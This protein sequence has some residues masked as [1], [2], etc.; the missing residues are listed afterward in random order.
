MI[1]DK[2][3]NGPLPL[4]ILYSSLQAGVC[5]SLSSHHTKIKTNTVRNEPCLNAIYDKA[6]LHST[7]QV[8]IA[9]KLWIT[10]SANLLLNCHVSIKHQIKYTHKSQ[11]IPEYNK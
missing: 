2:I 5:V 8:F 1:Q 4:I 3:L 6:I 9:Y 11:I 10:H 7:G